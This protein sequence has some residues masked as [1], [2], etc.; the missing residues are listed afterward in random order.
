MA[1]DEHGSLYVDPGD[2]VPD[3]DIQVKYY[4]LYQQ[5]CLEFLRRTR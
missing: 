4:Y 3:L 5:E 1:S 2:T